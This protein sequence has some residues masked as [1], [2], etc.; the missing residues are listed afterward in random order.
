M[1]TLNLELGNGPTMRD[2]EKGLIVGGNAF[3]VGSGYTGF[4]LFLLS[5][6]YTLTCLYY[7]MLKF[8]YILSLS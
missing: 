8:D 3:L 7:I 1:Q 4:S 5:F 6:F 2:R